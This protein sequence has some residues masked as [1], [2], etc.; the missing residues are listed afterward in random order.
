MKIFLAIC[1]II[2]ALGFILLSVICIAGKHID[3]DYVRWFI[4]IAISFLVTL[5]LL[6]M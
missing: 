4:E 5:F 3:R 1:L 6:D 2:E